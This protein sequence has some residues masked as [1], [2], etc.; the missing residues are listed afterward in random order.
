MKRV[1]YNLV[2]E[3]IAAKLCSAG[4]PQEHAHI[5][6]D[7]LVYADASGITSH[8]T[9]RLEHYVRRIAEGGINTHS[10][11]TAKQGAYAWSRLVDAEGGLGHVAALRAVHEG[12]Q[13]AKTHGI[14]VVSVTNT[15]HCGALSYYM[16]KIT[17]QDFIGFATLNTDKCVVPFGGTSP[18]LGT[19]PIAWGFPQSEDANPIIVDM[20]TSES[21]L[22]KIIAA[23]EKGERIPPHWAV[24]AEGNPTDK[25]NEVAALL[26]LAAH[27]GYAL[28]CVVEVLSAIFTASAF[29]PHLA[30]MYDKLNTKRNLGAFFLMMDAAVHVPKDAFKA[31]L[32]RMIRELH[33]QPCAPGVDGIRLPGEMEHAQYQQACVGGVA[34]LPEVCRYLCL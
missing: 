13:V 11:F 14:A 5:V 23:R 17:A 1:A 32:A 18:F 34:L 26:P 15:S 20:A 27:K 24:D 2:L 31:Q 21:A 3:A 16:R 7:V 29:G 33:A 8:G 9:I 25:P 19:N 10:S 22:G 6:A 4:V 12:V 30:P 28:A